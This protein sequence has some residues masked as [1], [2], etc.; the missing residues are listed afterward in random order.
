MDGLV[1]VSLCVCGAFDPLDFSGCQ[2]LGASAVRAFGFIFR[3][4]SEEYIFIIV[5]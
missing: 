4:D 3:K 2:R 1:S 5:M